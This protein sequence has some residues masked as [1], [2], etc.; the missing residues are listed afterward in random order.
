VVSQAGDYC[1]IQKRSGV[2]LNKVVKSREEWLYLMVEITELNYCFTV[3]KN[4][5]TSRCKKLQ[6]YWRKKM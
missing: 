2:D 3:F 5:Y 4:L 1:I 6:N